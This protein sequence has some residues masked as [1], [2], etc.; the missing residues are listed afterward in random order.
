MSNIPKMPKIPKKEHNCGLTIEDFNNDKQL[1]KFHIKFNC[2]K[3]KYHPSQCKK[4]KLVYTS[5][6]RLERHFKLKHTVIKPITDCNI[7]LNDT[8]GIVFSYLYDNYLYDGNVF[9]NLFLY[10]MMMTNNIVMLKCIFIKNNFTMSGLSNKLKLCLQIRENR[11]DHIKNTNIIHNWLTFDGEFNLNKKELRYLIMKGYLLT[12]TVKKNKIKN[13]NFFKKIKKNEEI[14]LYF[15]ES[16]I[17][18]IS[19]HNY[20]WSWVMKE[21]LII[22]EYI[23]DNIYDMQN[24]NI[25]ITIYKMLMLKTSI[26][27]YPKKNQHNIGTKK[28][29]EMLKKKL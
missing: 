22:L 10:E 6:G 2:G 21:N 20:E 3:L 17:D 8:W 29:I 15:Y 26:D 24:D 7:L 18:I 11:Y 4:C 9:G 25:D 5:T 27:G 16:I 28:I 12:F 13:I 1:F 23:L 19:K 14:Y